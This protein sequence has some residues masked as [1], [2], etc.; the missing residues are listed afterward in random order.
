MTKSNQYNMT[1][2]NY[3]KTFWYTVVCF[4]FLLGII[5]CDRN[6]LTDS[7]GSQDDL[8][9][10]QA[11]TT[12]TSQIAGSNMRSGFEQKS[13]VNEL[14]KLIPS[15]W[16]PQWKDASSFNFD[17]KSVVEVPLLYEGNELVIQ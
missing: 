12:F 14:G 13:G 8:L 16:Q 17:N 10:S 11:K 7:L 3:M 5:S 6:T 1:K 4:T 2:S 9:I 15:K